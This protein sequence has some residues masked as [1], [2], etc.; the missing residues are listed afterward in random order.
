MLKIYILI[1]FQNP[2]FSA[3]SMLN[4]FLIY[5]FHPVIQDFLALDLLNLFK[6]FLLIIY[7]PPESHHNYFY[8]NQVLFR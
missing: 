6:F 5:Y 2:R 1:Y 3:K 7:F 4:F 8:I